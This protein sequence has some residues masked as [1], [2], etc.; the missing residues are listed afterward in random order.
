MKYYKVPTSTQSDD[1]NTAS[2]AVVGQS[3]HTDNRFI[4]VLDQIN[5]VQGLEILTKQGNWVQVTI[6][7]GAVVVSVG[8][9][10]KV[11]SNGRLH[12]S[13]HRVIMS[14][15]S[16]VDNKLEDR[17]SCA[18]FG[19]P[20]EESIIQPQNELADME[21]PLLYRPFILAGFFK[22]ITTNIYALSD[23]PLRNYAGIEL[24]LQN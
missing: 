11:W 14:S 18:L 22:Y 15:S 24:V 2:S 7:K 21:H 19:L 8:D 20:E 23:N 17:Y 12:A 1:K 16:T 4:T 10:F 6:P 9:A 5:Q 13:R 3:P